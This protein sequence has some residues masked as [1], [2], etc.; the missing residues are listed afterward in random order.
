MVESRRFPNGMPVHSHPELLPIPWTVM[1]PHE[2]QAM[3]NHSQTLLR[4][5]ERGG[6]DP[7]EAV[8]VLEDRRYH[9]MGRLAAIERL[10][11]IIREA[12]EKRDARNN[13]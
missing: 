5:A 10:A 2:P 13:A 12:T 1:D 7:A 11:D 6:L 9:H 8:A 4:L 3:A